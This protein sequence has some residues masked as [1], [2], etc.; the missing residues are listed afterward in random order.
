MTLYP[1]ASNP[2]PEG[3]V[4]GHVTSEDAIRIRFARWDPLEGTGRR[5]TVTLLAGRTEFIEKYFEVVRELRARGFAVAILDW[6]GQGG[7]ER[8]LRNPRKGHVASFADY[9]RDL[10]AFV[11]DV[12]LPD[13]PAPHF[14]LAHSMGG[15]IFLEAVLAGHRWF[16][17]AV[18][19]APMVEL[20]LVPFS[21]VLRPTAK[22][23]AHLGLAGAFVPGG[24][25]TASTAGPFA[26]N[27]VTSDPARYA[28]AAEIVEAHPQLGLGAP[29]IGWMNAAY[30]AMAHLMAPE[31]VRLI[32]QPLLI[33]AA[34]AD[35]IVS[36]AA[37]EH[38]AARLIAGAQVVV[39]ASRHE[40]LM[41]R[42]I[43]RAQFWAAFDAFI[44]GSA[45]Y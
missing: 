19:T 2:V 44:P 6:R 18:L 10:A 43:F 34:G 1:T 32:R 8:L 45:P 17:R 9:Q 40:I 20:Q 3:A 11:R 13:C 28:R 35:S 24:G 31:T 16:D 36:N 4:S 37:I 27:P 30:D 41:E 33:V 26:R 39:P 5:G 42:D 22:L 12:L 25:S 15:A 7:S 21:S 38:L 23:L 14:A 29:T